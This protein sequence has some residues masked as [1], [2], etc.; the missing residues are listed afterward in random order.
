MGSG[1]VF[2]VAQGFTMKGSNTLLASQNYTFIGK[3]N[4]AANGSFIT[5]PIAPSNLNLCGNPFPS[6]LNAVEF[7]K[8]NI[9]TGGNIGSSG[10]IN[11]TL[12][13]WQ[14]SPSNNSHNLASYVGGY[15]ARNLSG[16]LASTQ[17]TGISGTIFEAVR[18]KIYIPVGQGFF[19]TGVATAGVRNITFKNS[20]REFIKED[21]INSNILYKTSSS[22]LNNLDDNFEEPDLFKRV[23][24]GYDNI[25]N[26]HRQILLAF[27]ENNADK[28]WNYG[29]DAPLFDSN[30]SEMC[31]IA[32]E[33]NLVINGVGFFDE[34]AIYPLLVKTEGTGIVKFTLDYT[35]NF[36]GAQQFYI[37]DNNTGLYH[38]IKIESFEINLEE[39]TYTD[40]FSLRFN[41]G[42]LNTNQLTLDNSIF[43]TYSNNNNH[44]HVYNNSKDTIVETVTLFNIIGQQINSWDT[45]NYAQNNMQIPV[46][47]LSVGTYI[48]KIK[49]TNGIV[50]K[51]I[52]IK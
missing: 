3:P 50:S 14:H 19:V 13:F 12:Y 42:T 30:P 23:R 33:N 43:V 9:P 39:G 20:Q 46:S 18:P 32:G 26:F 17:P 27:M 11:G 22:Q 44:I 16:S 28:D 8:D 31:F 5:I 10:A 36:E 49:T 1:G 52:I 24:L 51:K 29:Y 35:Q 37:H 48:V 25:A 38:N 6:A 7:I 21:N 2:S 4:N 34:A 47:Q 41:D 15:A 45:V 40:R